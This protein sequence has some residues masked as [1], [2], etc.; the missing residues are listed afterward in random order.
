MIFNFDYSLIKNRSY[1]K[2]SR[3][4][5]YAV[6]NSAYTTR[7]LFNMSTFCLFSQIF[8]SGFFSFSFVGRCLIIRE[9][10]LHGYDI[11]QLI[12]SRFPYI[13]LL[14]TKRHNFSSFPCSN[15]TISLTPVI[16]E[17]FSFLS[18]NSYSGNSLI[19]SWHSFDLSK[20]KCR[21]LFHTVYF[22]REWKPLKTT[23]AT[24]FYSINWN[25]MIV[26]Q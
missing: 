7:W 25:A 22:V 10:R 4:N 23:D 20:K 3:R 13:R 11:I 19:L 15:W 6:T 21:T 18:P 12:D 5:K 9:I 8:F 24:F 2:V 1:S 16:S 17:S 14:A 26:C